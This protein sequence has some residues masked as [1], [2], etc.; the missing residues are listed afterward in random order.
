MYPYVKNIW[1]RIAAAGCLV[2]AGTAAA[3]NL[4]E[5]AWDGSEG[6]AWTDPDN[7]VGGA[8]PGSNQTARLQND[9]VSYVVNYNT[10]Y[11]G[12]PGK[13]PFLGQ[14]YVS[15]AAVGNSHTVNVSTPITIDPLAGGS[16]GNINGLFFEAYCQLNVLPGGV[17]NC[18]GFLNGQGP[19]AFC[20][21]STS[22]ININGGTLDV[23]WY[24]QTTVNGGTLTVN[25]GLLSVH[26]P[27]SPYKGLAIQ[28]TGALVLHGGTVDVDRLSFG[29]NVTDPTET[30]TA[31]IDGGTLIVGPQAM[32]VGGNGGGMTGGTSGSG[33]ITMSGGTV[34]I[35]SVTRIG[36][37]TGTG[38]MWL[39]GGTWN[40]C[41][42]NANHITEIGM[43]DDRA[44]KSTPHGILT[45]ASNGVYN[46]KWDVQVGGNYFLTSHRLAEGAL[47]M[48]GGEL[49]ITNDSMVEVQF[50]TLYLSN[51]V[52][53]ADNVNVPI[54]TTDLGGGDIVTTTGHVVFAGG[55]LNT[56]GTTVDNG[57][58]LVVGGSASNAVLR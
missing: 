31:T 43:A 30:A 10:P 11:Y 8:V 19:L 4:P 42:P 14:L 18:D 34:S 12:E 48:N 22:E 40:Q 35:Y 17:V 32:Y 26:A 1:K 28:S 52:L 29:L 16:S 7:W 44:D 23:E 56:G 38:R 47:V 25:S 46:S 45:I 50:G 53:N 2:V 24:R 55:T 15:S 57:E 33:A 21:R 9:G 49:N 37:A 20:F 54:T 3:A 6:T 36:G 51:G 58:A 39:N 13:P 5:I 27:E 41:G